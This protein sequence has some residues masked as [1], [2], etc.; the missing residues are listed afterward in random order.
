MERKFRLF[1][2]YSRYSRYAFIDPTVRLIFSQFTPSRRTSLPVT[3][4]LPLFLGK[5]CF[6]RRGFESRWPGFD[7]HILLSY[8]ICIK[9]QSRHQIY[10][11]CN[12]LRMDESGKC[13]AN[14]DQWKSNLKL[15]LSIV[16]SNF[17]HSSPHIIGVKVDASWWASLLVGGGTFEY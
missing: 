7:V 4:V 17:C 10:W 11:L 15:I 12:S 9:L 16:N 5:G 1:N 2:T 8:Y 3:Y 6:F 14:Y 13:S